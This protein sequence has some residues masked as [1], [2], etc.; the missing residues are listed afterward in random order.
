M[1]TARGQDEALDEPRERPKSRNVTFTIKLV[2]NLFRVKIEDRKFSQLAAFATFVLEHV[3]NIHVKRSGKLKNLNIVAPFHDSFYVSLGVKR[4]EMS[5]FK[6][7]PIKYKLYVD[8]T[9]KYV[10][11]GQILVGM[12]FYDGAL[13]PV[14]VEGEQYKNYLESDKMSSTESKLEDTCFFEPLT[15][16]LS[17]SDSSLESSDSSNPLRYNTRDVYYYDTS[18]PPQYSEEGIQKVEN[19][20]DDDEVGDE[21]FEEELEFGTSD[22]STGSSDS[23]PISIEMEFNKEPISNADSLETIVF[24]NNSR[25]FSEKIMSDCFGSTRTEKILTKLW[26]KLDDERDDEPV[27][28]SLAPYS[29]SSMSKLPSD[30]HSETQS[31]T[32]DDQILSLGN[33]ISLP[34]KYAERVTLAADV[35][36]TT[37]CPKARPRSCPCEAP[38][39]V[40]RPDE[41]FHRKKFYSNLFS[42]SSAEFRQCGTEFH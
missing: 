16:K 13:L 41:S 20:F 26:R 7:E 25:S 14:H 10:R 22:S 4:D 31:Q 21:D 18:V 5:L 32:M 40:L 39:G 9:C 36:E 3:F 35:H 2:E 15:K 23:D 12:V 37:I 8:G 11:W 6:T 17:L 30:I 27:N 33:K 19:T 1:E 28:I 24:E 42:V 29:L 34:R 38:H